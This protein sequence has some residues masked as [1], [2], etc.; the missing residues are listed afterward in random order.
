MII[1]RGREWEGH[2]GKMGE[3]VTRHKFPVI[4]CPE[5]VRDS[6]VTIVH[7]TVLYT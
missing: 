1:A 6:M 7:N 3:G 2:G 5:D 4:K